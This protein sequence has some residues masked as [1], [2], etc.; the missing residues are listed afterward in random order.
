MQSF[1]LFLAEKLPKT[2]FN[3]V[4]TM[5]C[6]QKYSVQKS[7]L[8]SNMTES[9]NVKTIMICLWLALSAWW[10]QEARIWKQKM[11]SLLEAKIY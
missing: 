4:E 9:Q 3:A 10:A 5:C 6:D 11:N 8:F 1:S 2:L 7:E